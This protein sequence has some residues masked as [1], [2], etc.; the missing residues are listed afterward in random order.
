M[1]CWLCGSH[2]RSC[3]ASTTKD[4]KIEKIKTNEVG[5]VKEGKKQG[6]MRNMLRVTVGLTGD[7]Y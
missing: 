1:V 3:M 6:A 5:W 7:G 4:R 2:L